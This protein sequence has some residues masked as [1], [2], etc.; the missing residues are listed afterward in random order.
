MWWIAAVAVLFS[1]TFLFLNT[2]ELPIITALVGLM[3]ALPSVRNVQVIV[4]HVARSST[5]WN[6]KRYRWVLLEH[7]DRCDLPSRIDG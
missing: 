3:F 1:V 6:F 4:I 2:A 5:H 7:G